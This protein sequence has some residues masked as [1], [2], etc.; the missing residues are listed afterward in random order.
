MR[1]NKNIWE[2]TNYLR[3]SFHSSEYYLIV[4]YCAVVNKILNSYSLSLDGDLENKLT[5]NINLFTDKEKVL[6]KIITNEYRFINNFEEV[7]NRFSKIELKSNDELF[8]LLD[9][10]QNDSMG[11]E[12]G[13][14]TSISS[15]IDLSKSI[16]AIKENSEILD[17]CSGYGNFLLNIDNSSNKKGIEINHEACNISNMLFYLAENETDII[18]GDALL[19]DDYK[20][21]FDYIFCEA[22]FG[23][24]LQREQLNFFNENSN[25][26]Y[27]F[28]RLS[29]NWAF[30]EKAISLLNN[31]G[32]AILVMYNAPLFQLNDMEYRKHLVEQEYIEAVIQL[33]SR[34]LLN[35]SIAVSIVVL[36]KNKSEHIKMIDASSEFKEGRRQNT[37]SVENINHILNSLNSNDCI[38]NTQ[39]I[40]ENSYNLTPNNY[41]DTFEIQNPLKI[42]NFA[43]VFRGVQISARELDKIVVDNDEYDYKVLSL[44]DISEHSIK[45]EQAHNIKVNHSKWNRYLLQNGDF[46]LS[47]KGTKVKTAVYDGDDSHTIISGNLMVLRIN[48]SNI[49]PY[50]LKIFIDSKLGQKCIKRIQTGA[51]IVSIGKQA[52]EN[53]EIPL[54]P[55]NEQEEI[56]AKYRAKLDELQYYNHKILELSESIDNIYESE[57]GGV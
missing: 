34:L 26:A 19:F 45:Y 18:N 11:K 31:D 5:K 20:Q 50:Y 6:V 2:L 46:I 12:N 15:I 53:M 25:L 22:P 23:M 41:T 57:F 42:K 51:T 56:V 1:E 9:I 4:V 36:S 32:K 13:I 30:A 3:G 24:R 54:I 49:N 55:V 37:M 8:L 27:D 52:I 33:P 43:E 47:A 40:K 39:Q 21:K 48:N 29:S 16:F 28:R 7:N 38:I 17:M 35:S 14:S 44:G 10:I